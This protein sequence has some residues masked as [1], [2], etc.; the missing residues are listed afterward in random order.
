MNQAGTIKHLPGSASP[1]VF[2]PLPEDDPKRRRPDLT[3]ARRLL[4]YDPRVPLAEGLR[5]TLSWF[6]AELQRG[7]AAD[8]RITHAV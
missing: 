5:R 1:V 6:A 3:R 4:G 7:P 2:R 8:E